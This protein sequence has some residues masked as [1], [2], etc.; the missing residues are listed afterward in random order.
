MLSKLTR[1][2]LQDA[3]AAPNCSYSKI[4]ELLIRLG[5]GSALAILEAEVENE[6]G[7]VLVAPE[8][9][10][11]DVYFG[12]YTFTY[13]VA[14]GPVDLGNIR[15]VYTSFTEAKGDPVDEL[16]QKLALIKY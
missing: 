12:P 4:R 6:D 16:S 15:T 7:A 9:A 10:S 3:L 8:T 13:L 1:S 2:S 11:S 14:Q 5:D